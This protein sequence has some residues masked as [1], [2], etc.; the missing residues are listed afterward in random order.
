MYRSKD[1]HLYSVTW[2]MLRFDE[3]KFSDSGSAPRTL[4]PGGIF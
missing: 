3:H 4:L 1:I 2:N